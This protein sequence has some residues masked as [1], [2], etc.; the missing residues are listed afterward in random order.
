[1]AMTIRECSEECGNLVV[2][3]GPCDD[4]QDS[5]A[6]FSPKRRAGVER[7]RAFRAGFEVNEFDYVGAN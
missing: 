1:M 7:A 6:H 4:C 2:V 3:D 5:T